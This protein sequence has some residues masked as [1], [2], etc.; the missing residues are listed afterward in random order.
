[1]NVGSASIFRR[2]R[3]T[4]IAITRVNLAGGDLL[5][6]AGDLPRL[7]LAAPGVERGRPDLPLVIHGQVAGGAVADAGLLGGLLQVAIRPQ[8]AIGEEVPELLVGLV[9][10][11]Q[12]TSP[13]R[14]LRDLDR[15][16]TVISDLTV[17]GSAGAGGDGRRT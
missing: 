4:Q 16:R 17:T 2:R 8:V 5:V 6:H 15:H 1:M 11:L 9:G 10:L 3:P 12:G 7:L 14:T 13:G